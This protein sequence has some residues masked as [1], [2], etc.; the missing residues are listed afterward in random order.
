MLIII[1]CISIIYKVTNTNVDNLHLYSKT[2]I[3]QHSL[4][5]FAACLSKDS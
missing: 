5:G 1:S 2:R 3:I 4:L